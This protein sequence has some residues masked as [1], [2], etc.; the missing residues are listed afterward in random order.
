PFLIGVPVLGNNRSNTLG[1]FQCQPKAGRR[2]IVE[3]VDRKTLRA[4]NLGKTIDDA[5]DIVER[6]VKL[7]A[8]RHVR[9]TKPRK[10]GRDDMELLREL[11]H[12]FTEHVTRARKSVK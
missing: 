11:R 12:E 9:L 6:I 8:V 1:M 2:P 7:I 10:V 5:R 4:D 3:Y